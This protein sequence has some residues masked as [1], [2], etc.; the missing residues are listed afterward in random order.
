RQDAAGAARRRAGLP[1][2]P[3][4][5]HPRPVRLLA[6]LA[7]AQ[8]RGRPTGAAMTTSLPPTPV[9]QPPTDARRPP[10]RSRW[11]WLWPAVQLIVALPLTGPALV[12]LLWSP[13]KEP[14]P[15]APA[16]ESPSHSEA[17]RLVGPDRVSISPDTPLGKKLEVAPVGSESVSAPLLTVT[18][19]V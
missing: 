18:G 6:L 19:S 7:P 15:P 4:H 8:R 2:R 17:V 10:A 12:Y 13:H 9:K 3:A 14:T 5:V 1:G 11:G 16:E